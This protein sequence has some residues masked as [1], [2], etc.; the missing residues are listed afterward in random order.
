MREA[1]LM[2]GAKEYRDLMSEAEWEAVRR[3]IN[4][5]EQ[6]ASPDDRTTFAVPDVPGLFTYDDGTWQMIYVVPDDA[7]LVIRTIAHVFD[8]PA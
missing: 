6:D 8:L 5:L 4:R 7:T 2:P 1:I 3:R